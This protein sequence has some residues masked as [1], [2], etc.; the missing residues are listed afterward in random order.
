METKIKDVSHLYM[1]CPLLSEEGAKDTKS[2]TWFDRVS[3]GKHKPILSRLEDM[4]EEDAKELLKIRYGRAGWFN[5]IYERHSS[6]CVDFYFYDS[7]Q[8][9]CVSQL[10]WDTLNAE[11]VAYL[12]SKGY[13]LFNLIPSGE[14]IDRKTL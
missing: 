11:S 5:P 9:K 14:A 12:L 10:D 2:Y 1:G 3:D 13:D 4:T 6:L 8:K 7:N